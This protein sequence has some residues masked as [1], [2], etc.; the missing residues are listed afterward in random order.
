MSSSISSSRK[1]W[2]Q[3]ATA[4]DKQQQPAFEPAA[5]QDPQ[6]TQPADIAITADFSQLIGDWQ[7]SLGQP[8]TFLSA[9]DYMLQ[10]VRQRYQVEDA[11]DAPP[12]EFVL[13]LT[14][15]ALA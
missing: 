8:R 1:G 3:H 2:P 13:W 10:R 11:D 7:E 9:G 15:W 14:P 5:A 4:I 12:D 6:E